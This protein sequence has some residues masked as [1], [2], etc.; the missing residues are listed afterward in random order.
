MGH[1]HHGLGHKSAFHIKTVR[2]IFPT[3]Q[4]LIQLTLDAY[5]MVGVAA[6]AL[7]FNHSI[8]MQSPGVFRVHFPCS[9]ANIVP[10]LW[11]KRKMQQGQDAA[12]SYCLWKTVL[13]NVMRNI[14]C[15]C[16]SILRAW[17]GWLG[18]PP[19]RARKES[20]RLVLRRHDMNRS[21]NPEPGN[22]LF[23]VGFVCFHKSDI[24]R[25]RFV[26]LWQTPSMDGPSHLFCC[27]NRVLF[28]PFR[29]FHS[30]SKQGRHPQGDEPILDLKNNKEFAKSSLL[31]LRDQRAYLLGPA[32]QREG[33]RDHVLVAFPF[34]D[35]IQYFP[36]LR[37]GCQHSL[38]I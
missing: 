29:Y 6:I 9:Q 18:R 38:S 2:P 33:R 7:D 15:E 1:Q 10:N 23:G 16:N 31:R 21:S 12:G 11:F 3:W 4:W 24:Q 14:F 8:Q 20:N 22:E 5:L 28:V 30:K 19:I 17:Y 27:T 34:K 36:F 25:L 26:G 13:L 32:R 37:V 35:K